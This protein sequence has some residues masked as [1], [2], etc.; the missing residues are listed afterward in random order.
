[1]F[2]LLV[3]SLPETTLAQVMDI[4]NTL[5]A[6]NPFDILKGHLLEAHMHTRRWM[7]CSSWDR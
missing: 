4:I 6:F 2:D 5:P 7:C 3:A 1:M